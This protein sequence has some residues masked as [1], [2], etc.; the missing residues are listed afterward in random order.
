MENVVIRFFLKK[1][2]DENKKAIT[3]HKHLEVIT[4]I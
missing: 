1:I 2:K 3:V 4:Y